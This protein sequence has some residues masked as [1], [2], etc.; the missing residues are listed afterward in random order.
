VYLMIDKYDAVP[1][2]TQFFEGSFESPED[3]QHVA[4]AIV[5]GS[6]IAVDNGCVFAECFNGANPPAVAQTYE[7][8][9][10][11]TTQTF[12]LTGSTEWFLE[13]IDVDKVHPVIQPLLR[14]A[15]D[16]QLRTS[17]LFF[18]RAPLK[19]VYANS[20]PK[21]FVSWDAQNEQYLLQNYDPTGKRYFAALIAAATDYAQQQRLPYLPGVTSH[22]ITGDPAGEIIDADKAADLAHDKD[23]P[24]LIDP[25]TRR[26]ATSSYGIINFTRHGL[27]L[28][29]G[30]S[31][32]NN[33]A[34]EL[35]RGYDLSIPQNYRHPKH[36][37]LPADA[38]PYLHDPDELQG[39]PI[40]QI[41]DLL[42][43]IMQ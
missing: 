27:E 29:R 1:S 10:R 11:P 15:T 31:I 19:A 36:S 9:G 6:V 26:Y 4:Q 28:S 41:K 16:L 12:G 30:G 24:I 32:D 23:M 35:F 18:V 40:A 43:W 20:L 42:L 17:G 8:K 3:V 22:N 37:P 14:D 39:M 25:T 5:D 7:I 13:M 21:E 2:T 34:V 38:L 33:Y